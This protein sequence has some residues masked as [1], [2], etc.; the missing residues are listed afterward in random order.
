MKITVLGTGMVGQKLAGRLAGLGHDV[1]VGTRDVQQTM[2][3]TEPDSMGHPPYAA[4][5]D[6]HPQVRLLP[7][8][9][10]GAHGEAIVNAT[11]GTVSLQALEAVGAPNLTGK[12]V[13]DLALP[14]D[15]SEGMPPRLTIA[16]TDSLGEQIQRAYPGARVVKTL[17]TT[18]V[19]VM[20][21]PGLLPSQT[22]LFLAGDD[23]DAKQTAKGL[24]QEF[25]WPQASIIDLG[26]IQTARACEMYAQ[27]YFTLVNVLGTFE[28][29]IAVVSRKTTDV[30]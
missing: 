25:G 20:V 8:P 26:G 30:K 4:W 16:N 9:E 28:L 2:A 14:L 15:F 13:I 23:A 22:N 21:E 29:N 3:R 1:A 6:D 12:A 5:Q 17:N 11:G 27:M 18:F 19:N 24:L 7:Y 10:A